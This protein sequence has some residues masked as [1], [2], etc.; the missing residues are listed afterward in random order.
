MDERLRDYLT[1]KSWQVK[2]T[3]QIVFTQM[4]FY[5]IISPASIS[6][7]GFVP[8][9]SSL[10]IYPRPHSHPPSCPHHQTSH[11]QASGRARA[12]L[13]SAFAFQL[14][15]ARHWATGPL[16]SLQQTFTRVS[17]RRELEPGQSW[18]ELAPARR[19]K[20]LALDLTKDMRH[21]HQAVMVMQSCNA[22]CS[23]AVNIT[24]TPKTTNYS[25]T[26]D[27]LLRSI[28]PVKPLM[29]DIPLQLTNYV[30]TMTSS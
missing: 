22:A 9:F 6:A 27:T 19:M 1:L 3:G 23:T 7:G 11:H 18:P 10:R 30:L 12:L 29:T 4:I 20:C 28:S 2:V 25:F 15:P 8:A 17:R 24:R 16:C 13:I 21:Q 26:V 5:P 14:R